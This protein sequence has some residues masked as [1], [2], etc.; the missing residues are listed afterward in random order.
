MYGPQSQIPCGKSPTYEELRERD[1]HTHKQGKAKGKI[2]SKQLKEP[3]N[4][5]QK[6]I[7]CGWEDQ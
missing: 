5:G 7:L 2:G 4:S 3:I 6:G 1:T